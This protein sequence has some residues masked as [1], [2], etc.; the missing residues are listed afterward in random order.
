MPRISRRARLLRILHNVVNQRIARRAVRMVLKE[1]KDEPDIFED[2]IDLFSISLLNKANNKRYLFR[3]TRYRKGK[4]EKRFIDDL[5]EEVEN[6]AETSL[7]QPTQVE[8]VE[9]CGSSDQSS[10]LQPW[11][12]DS[13]FLQK[14]RMSRDSFVFLLSKIKNHPVF[15]TAKKKKQAPVEYQL[16][17]WLKYVG[18]EG[19]GASNANQRNT[20]GIGYGTADSYRKRVTI[21]I[22][23]LSNEY[24][25]WPDAEERAKICQEIFQKYDFPHCCMVGDGTLFPF[26][27]EPET[28]DAPDYSGRKYG[29]SLTTLIFNDHNK[30]IRHFLAGFPG[31]AHDNRVFKATRLYKK[32][33]DYFAPREYCIGDS[34]FENT[35]FMVSA[36]KK[37][38]GESM[39]LSHEK[40]NEKL[41]KLRITSEHTIGILKGR[42]PWL[43]SIRL[44]IKENKRSLKRIV[45]L[46]EATI[47]VH[48]MLV[49]L[50][51]QEKEDWIDKDDASEIDTAECPPYQEGD[52]LNQGMPD[53]A[54][55]DQ[56]RTRLMHYFEEQHY[57]V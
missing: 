37:P 44:K 16:M 13:E 10:K 39:P 18:T 51:E 30:K 41:A 8:D 15:H 52:A 19:S 23:S 22:L 38:K 28:E 47:V 24:I 57:F 25:K 5:G 46:I 31:S 35:P 11:L 14:Y 20:F 53:G 7:Q 4:S 21:A 36:F 50:G 49:D 26:A 27:F 48:N 54:P 34:A 33:N 9:S 45:E 43:R 32:P 40:F 29:Y 42:F 6:V 56:R 2:A 1:D 17:T 3:S 55:N 12:N